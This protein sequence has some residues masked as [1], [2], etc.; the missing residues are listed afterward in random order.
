MNSALEDL[1]WMFGHPNPPIGYITLANWVR[2]SA[3]YM[4]KYMLR[5][6]VNNFKSYLRIN[7]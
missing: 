2:R 5:D 3:Y 6:I 4:E 1:R 7:T